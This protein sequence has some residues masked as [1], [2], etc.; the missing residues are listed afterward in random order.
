VWPAGWP[1][2]RLRKE[3]HA[4]AETHSGSTSAVESLPGHLP[5][6]Q[7]PLRAGRQTPLIYQSA[8]PFAMLYKR[9]QIEEAIARVFAPNR[10]KPL[11]ELRTRIKRLLDLDRSIGRKPRSKDT[12]DANFGFFSEEPPGTGADITFSEYEAFA[13]L[14]GMLILEHGWPQSFAVSIMRRARLD[15]EREHARILRQDP[16]KLFDPQAIRAQA[17]PGYIEVTNTDPVFLTLASK[18]QH[19]SDDT[20]AA[21]LCAVCHGREKVAEF[22]RAVGASSLTLFEVVTLAHKLHQELVETEPKP[23]GRASS[24]TKLV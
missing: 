6:E 15:L 24:G 10:Q 21:P 3:G 22:T 19:A 8:R 1:D 14:N 18:A 4:A 2:V 9:N 13:L 12:E 17:R 5:K 11:L 16:A 20:Q 23:R 7:N